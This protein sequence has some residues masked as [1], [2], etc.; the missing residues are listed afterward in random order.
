MAEEA[1]LRGIPCRLVGTLG[2]IDWVESHLAEIGLPWIENGD[3]FSSATNGMEILVID[4]YSIPIE[5]EFLSDKRWQYRVAIADQ[6]TPNYFANLVIHPG[7]DAS[8]FTGDATAILFGA[9]YLPIRRS[10]QKS[11]RNHDRLGL[12]KVVV[13]GG[14]T[15]LL[16]FSTNVARIL[17]KSQKFSHASFFCS[18][19]LG[20]DI[21]QMDNRF[22]AFLPGKKL[23]GE[24]A[25]ADLV[26]T[27]AS[28]SSLEILA[29]EI[30]MG[31][32]CLAENQLENLKVLDDLGVAHVLPLQIEGGTLKIDEESL[33]A[34]LADDRYRKQLQRCMRGVL[35]LQGSRRILDEIISR[36]KV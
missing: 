33:L 6:A 24:L 35:D 2:G 9:K 27:T 22:S 21:C 34:F 15:D 8:W 31:I 17:I 7:L 26:L 23:A 13:F 14:G 20:N 3:F 32:A 5:D 4:S 29:M 10:I 19:E 16:S 11:S 28:T 25:T 36:A 1:I 30:P 12:S 18:E